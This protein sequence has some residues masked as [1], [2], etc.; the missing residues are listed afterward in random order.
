MNT[1]VGDAFSST[2]VGPDRVRKEL[3]HVAIWFADPAD[4]DACLGPGGG[5]TTPFDKDGQA[6][7]T[8]LSSK[9]FLPGSPLP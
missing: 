1:V 4:D 7:V 9:N 5:P 6:G 3:N 8:V 2:L